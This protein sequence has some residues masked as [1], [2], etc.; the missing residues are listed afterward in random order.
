[1]ATEPEDLWVEGCVRVLPRPDRSERVAADRARH[2]EIRWD[3]RDRREIV[4]IVGK[5]TFAG[6]EPL[7]LALTYFDVGRRDAQQGQRQKRRCQRAHDSIGPSRD[8]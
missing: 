1:M 2:T 7:G 6:S 5:R 8:G 4:G 3:R